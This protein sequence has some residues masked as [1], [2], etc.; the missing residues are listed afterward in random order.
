MS[1][2]TNTILTKWGQRAVVAIQGAI[3]SRLFNNPPWGATLKKRTV[4]AKKKRGAGAPSMALWDTGA[5][6]KA[7]KFVV[8]AARGFALVSSDG[9]SK[10]QQEGFVLG[11]AAGH[12]AQGRNPFK[13]NLPAAKGGKEKGNTIAEVGVAIAAA[14]LAAFAKSEISKAKKGL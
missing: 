3:R 11:R 13:S 7:M 5:F 12:P 6:S 4:D 14:E 9:K 1:D 8:Y 10:R 2:L